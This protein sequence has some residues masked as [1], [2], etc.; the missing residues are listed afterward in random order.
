MYTGFNYAAWDGKAIALDDEV[1]SQLHSYELKVDETILA[2]HSRSVEV[3]GKDGKYSS[4]QVKDN[5]CK[6]R[7][8]ADGEYEIIGSS[9]RDGNS[10]TY[11][12]KL[13]TLT[14]KNGEFQ[15]TP[16]Q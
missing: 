5:K 10:W 12:K 8:F 14:L 11:D 2:S 3:R 4:V 13:G 6:I 1:L 16:A 15:Y 9:N 7:L